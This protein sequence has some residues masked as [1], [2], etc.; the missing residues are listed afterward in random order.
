MLPSSV[1]NVCPGAFMNCE[2]LKSVQL[3]EGLLTLGVEE[4]SD[5]KLDNGYAFA[6]SAIESVKIP[7][8]LKRIEIAT[9]YQCAELKKVTFSEGLQIIGPRAFE[10]TGL[11]SIV[12][13]HSVITVCSTAFYNC[14][15][16]RNVRLNNELEV[17]GT[18]ERERDCLRG[19]F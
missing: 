17:I 12:L 8:T 11:E 10:E 18:Y 7:S 9:F 19:A 5:S 15:T 16:L 2:N 13:P 14:T 6:A 4:R 1:R 3:N